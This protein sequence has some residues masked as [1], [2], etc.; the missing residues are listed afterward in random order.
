MKM[1]NHENALIL[2]SRF[3]KF[4]WQFHVGLVKI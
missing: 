4:N 3:Q 2:K 1:E